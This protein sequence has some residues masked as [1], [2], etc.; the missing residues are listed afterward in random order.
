MISNEQ[1][2]HDL[3]LLVVKVQLQPENSKSIPKQVDGKVHVSIDEMYFEA[4]EMA[5]TSINK[6]F[7]D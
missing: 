2:A 1:R 6:R 5:L 7:A 3:A 4:Y